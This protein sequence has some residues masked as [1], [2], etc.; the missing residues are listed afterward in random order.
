MTIP[1]PS[2]S[3]YSALYAHIEGILDKARIY[4]HMSS[5]SNLLTDEGKRAAMRSH[6]QRVGWSADLDT[7]DAELTRRIESAE[8]ARDAALTPTAPAGDETATQ[9]RALRYWSRVRPVLD[10]MQ[11]GALLT[12]VASRIESADAADVVTLLD[13][14]PDYLTTR[15]ITNGARQVIDGA[16]VRRTP[17]AAAHDREATFAR[18]MRN[19]VFAP[20]LGWAREAVASPTGPTTP[21]PTVQKLGTVERLEARHRAEAAA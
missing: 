6:D 15:G 11:G 3:T 1:A 12:E 21:P 5:G 7:I 19:A 18:T 20:A 16:M 13:E 9:V 10:K 14:L 8:A 2:T 4:S 17:A